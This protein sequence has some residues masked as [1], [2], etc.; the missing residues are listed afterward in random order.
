MAVVAD[1]H[2]LKVFAG[3]GVQVGDYGGMTFPRKWS[4][5]FARKDFLLFN[6]DSKILI[7]H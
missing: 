2:F 6:A 1:L 4:R 7:C 5:V 3:L